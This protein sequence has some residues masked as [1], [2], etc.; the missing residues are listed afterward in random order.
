MKR[1]PNFA[2]ITPPGILKTN[3]LELNPE[4]A[5]VKCSEGGPNARFVIVH[6]NG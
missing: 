3:R 1:P 4:F 6:R 5:A 2:G